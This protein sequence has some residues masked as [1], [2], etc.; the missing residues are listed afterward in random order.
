MKQWVAMEWVAI[1]RDQLD[2]LAAQAAG[3]NAK[4]QRL[5][6]SIT[7]WDAEGRCINCKA[8]LP[9]P[10]AFI[11][12]LQDNNKTWGARICARCGTDESKIVE[13]ARQHVHRAY[14]SMR[15]VDPGSA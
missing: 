14:P 2:E 9:Q 10:E 12:V 13:L 11:V 5:A 3:G 8:A 4:A 6:R 15:I 1:A 7:N